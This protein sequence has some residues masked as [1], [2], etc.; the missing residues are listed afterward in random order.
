M[1][2]NERIE[3]ERR[4]NALSGALKGAG[5]GHEM[6]KRGAAFRI[7]I[8]GQA[9]AD[10]EARISKLVSEAWRNG[11]FGS[12]QLVINRT[13][14]DLDNATERQTRLEFERLKPSIIELYFAEA[15]KPKWR[16]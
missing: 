16:K 7:S 6:R 13:L 3:L 9:A 11:G 10:N 14:P 5:I 15:K 12:S 1:Q 2:R 8:D 4:A